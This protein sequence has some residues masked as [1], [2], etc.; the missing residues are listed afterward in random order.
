MLFDKKKENEV[1]YP[2]VTPSVD[3]YHGSDNYTVLLDV[4]GVSSSDVELSVEA[5]RLTIAATRKA[6]VQEPVVYRRTLALPSS[7]DREGISAALENGVLSVTLP[8]RAQAKPRQ[9]PVKA[10]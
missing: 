4:P 3:V 6:G 5:E 2:S 1:Q 7:V 10:A 8:K 9:I